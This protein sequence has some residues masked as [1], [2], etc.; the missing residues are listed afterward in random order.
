M[1]F[2]LRNI[3]LQA[4]ESLQEQAANFP[5]RQLVAGPYHSLKCHR[6]KY[7]QID[8]VQFGFQLFIY[9]NKPAYLTVLGIR[10]QFWKS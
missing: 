7:H 10:K 2:P 4:L 3:S 6:K 5:S 1:L 8:R 9:L